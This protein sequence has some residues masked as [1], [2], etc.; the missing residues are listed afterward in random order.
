[1]YDAWALR[2]QRNKKK[3]DEYVFAQAKANSPKKDPYSLQAYIDSLYKE[4]GLI[5][6]HVEVE[7]F[8]KFKDA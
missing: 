2:A 5:P 3:L 4:C 1:M 7:A 6:P 8:I